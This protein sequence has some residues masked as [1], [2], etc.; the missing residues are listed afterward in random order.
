MIVFQCNYKIIVTILQI[1]KQDSLYTCVLVYV[2]VV[3]S[4]Y[5]YMS[6]CA[7]VSWQRNNYFKIVSWEI[8]NSPCAVFSVIPRLVYLLQQHNCLTSLLGEGGGGG[9]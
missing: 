3:V 5:A 9:A 8:S 6:A 4:D 1:A 2:C 7:C